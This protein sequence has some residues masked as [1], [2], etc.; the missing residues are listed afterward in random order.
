MADFFPLERSERDVEN[1]APA[2]IEEDTHR[3][4]KVS[5]L[6]VPGVKKI[7]MPI[8][9]AKV[10]DFAVR[11]TAAWCTQNPEHVAAF[12]SATGSLTVNKETPAVGRGAITGLVRSFMTAFPDPVVRMDELRVQG[13]V[14][15]YRWTPLGTNTGPGGTG[16]RVRISGFEEW[17]M[18]ADVLISSSQGHFEAEE[19]QRQL[20]EGA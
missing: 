9:F 11:Y 18:G 19:Y 16:R 15:E 20:E 3:K 5:R 10:R 8:G 13:E 7:I 1:G 12:F 6:A 14:V 2:R 4:P 17:C